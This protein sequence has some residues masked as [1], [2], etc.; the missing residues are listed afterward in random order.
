MKKFLLWLP[1]IVALFFFQWMYLEVRHSR[2]RFAE[3]E[4]VYKHDYEISMENRA[5]KKEIHHAYAEVKMLVHRR[6]YVEGSK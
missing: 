6:C 1:F 3:F 5:F 2:E 4:W